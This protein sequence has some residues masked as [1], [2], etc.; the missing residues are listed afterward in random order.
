MNPAGTRGTGRD[1]ESPAAVL[2][3]SSNGDLRRDLTE[4]VR[5]EGLNPM[6]A[7]GRD[8]ALPLLDGDEADLVVLDLDPRSALG[9]DFCWEIRERTTA[10]LLVLADKGE[11]AA[12]V[13]GLEIGADAFLVKPFT[14]GILLAQLYAL[15]RRIGEFRTGHAGQLDSGGLRINVVRHEVTLD[16]ERVDLTPT[17][18]RI[19][20]CLVR[21]AGRAISHRSLLR[22]AQGYESETSEAR[23]ILKVHIHNLRGKIEPEPK[24]PRFILGVRGFGYL[25]ER[26]RHERQD[27]DKVV[28]V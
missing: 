17:E 3:V 21:N 13:H 10:P 18:Y 9:A 15:L 25:F 6:R 11:E 2:V 5:G 4:V 26:R 23:E 8:S 1:G 24:T 28:A 14:V 22:Q 27:L 7:T 16:G 12:L 19:L 20:S